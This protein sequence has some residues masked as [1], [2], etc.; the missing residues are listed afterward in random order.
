MRVRAKGR[1]AV[2]ALVA[3][4][5]AVAGIAFASVIPGPDGVIHGCYKASGRALRVV[6]PNEG[7]GSRERP[8]EW[9]QTGPPGSSAPAGKLAQGAEPEGL[10][11]V[12]TFAETE[13]ATI[14]VPGP[15]KVLVQGSVRVAPLVTGVF[16]HARLRLV[17]PGAVSTM[18]GG[19]MG[20]GASIS[21]GWVFD[22]A[23][24]GDHT[25]A[26]DLAVLGGT[27]NPVN[28]TVTMLYV[29]SS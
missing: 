21:V 29:P 18:P 23:A 10:S 28:E 5:A 19:E 22:V 2:L 20:S 26:L 3:G 25:F 1:L 7:C 8:I 17:A 12:G 13:S 27:I 6:G 9:N 14:T 15:G 16:T 11:G 24:A 4:A